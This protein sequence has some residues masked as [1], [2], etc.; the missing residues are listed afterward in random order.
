M[1]F[2]LMQVESAKG[3]A[4]IPTLSPNQCKTRHQMLALISSLHFFVV[5]GLK[6]TSNNLFVLMDYNSNQ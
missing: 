6:E 5:W 1:S 2:A 3:Q 4:K